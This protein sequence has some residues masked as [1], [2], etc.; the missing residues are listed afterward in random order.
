MKE[1]SKLPVGK[2]TVME[3]RLETKIEQDGQHEV[4]VYEG[5][6]QIVQMGEWLYLRYEEAETL[7]K[8]IIKISRAGKFTIIRRAGE[9][10]LSRLSFDSERL[11]TAQIPTQAGVVEIATETKQMLQ[12]YKQ[13]PFSGFVQVLYTI[14]TGTQTLGNYEMSLQFTT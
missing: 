9:E 6:G 2:G 8:V 1:V 3:Y 4:F 5:Q 12:N 7:N 14:G 10:L 11:G 13:H